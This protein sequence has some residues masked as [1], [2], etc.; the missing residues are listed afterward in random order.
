MVNGDGAIFSQ[1]KGVLTALS[2]RADVD[3]P[4]QA[5]QGEI[6]GFD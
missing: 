1:R 3:I 4:Y 5:V 2:L 6:G